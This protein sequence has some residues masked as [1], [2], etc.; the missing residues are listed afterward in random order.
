M[1]YLLKRL[2]LRLHLAFGRLVVKFHIDWQSS[3]E[4]R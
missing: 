3:V 1:L 4:E 2:I